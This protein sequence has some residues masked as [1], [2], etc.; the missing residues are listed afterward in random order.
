V[1]PSPIPTVERPAAGLLLA[2]CEWEASLLPAAQLRLVAQLREASAAGPAGLIFVLAERIHAV[3][4]PVRAFWRRIAGEASVRL[5][6][7]AIVT[8]SWAVETEALGFATIAARL[9]LGLRLEVFAEERD[10]VDWASGVLEAA[11]LPASA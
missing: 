5:A 4:H 3:P 2:R 10:A 6:A 1:V 9:G 11:R 8:R 7:M